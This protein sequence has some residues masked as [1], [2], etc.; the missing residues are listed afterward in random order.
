M[1]KMIHN[2]IKGEIY[3]HTGRIGKND[4]ERQESE[5][6]KQYIQIEIVGDSEIDRQIQ[7]QTHRGENREREK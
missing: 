3:V 5:R 1:R 6:K 4:Y 7:R 2:E